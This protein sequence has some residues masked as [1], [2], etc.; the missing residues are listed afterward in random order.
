MLPDGATRYNTSNE[1]AYE[2]YAEQYAE[3][4]FDFV[5]NGLGRL[6]PT[7]SLYLVTGCD[8]SPSWGAAVIH[9]PTKSRRCAV[10]FTVG[11]VAG[12]GISYTTS[13]KRQR[14]PNMRSFPQSGI[15]PS[16][17]VEENQC[18]FARGLTITIRKS[19]LKSRTS[20][21]ELSWINGSSNDACPSFCSSSRSSSS[22]RSATSWFSRRSGSS[23]PSSSGSRRTSSAGRSDVEDSD[24]MSCASESD[25]DTKFINEHPSSDCEMNHEWVSNLTRT[26][27]TS[28]DALYF[29]D[30]ESVNMHQSAHSQQGMCGPLTSR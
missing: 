27:L 16:A 17:Q 21:V 5:E 13:S 24:R 3:S 9:N 29:L 28:A 18:V 26:P 19:F 15:D 22:S 14:G 12:G 2:D 10:N 11:G 4:W 25:S 7:S 1:R 6:L 20:G 30:V 23:S 8:K